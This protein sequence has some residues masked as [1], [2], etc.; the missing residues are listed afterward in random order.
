[1]PGSVRS[2]PRTLRCVAASKHP[3]AL[4]AALAAAAMLSAGA[5][6]AAAVPA[7][8]AL[9]A[10][11][12]VAGGTGTSGDTGQPADTAVRP[13]PPVLDRTLPVLTPDVG[14]VR[15][16]PAGDSSGGAEGDYLKQYTLRGVGEH[17]EV[18][19]AT[20]PAP[21]GV[22]GTAFPAGDCRNELPGAG[23]VTDEQVA[24]IVRAFDGTI[25]PT[26][27]AA[28]SVAPRRDGTRPA[29]DAL[30]DGP[31][32][33]FTGAADRTVLLVDNI[34]DD[35]FH[36]LARN[37][38]FLGGFFS[39][40]H[41]NLTDR[42][43]LTVDAFDW[44]HRNGA[45]PPS[46]P[47]AEPCRNQLARPYAVEATIAHEYQHL[48]QSYIDPGEET[49][50]DEG[51]SDYA[52]GLAGYSHAAL[53]QGEPGADDAIR[54]YLGF[55]TVVSAANPTPS[56]CG[57]P[58]NSL[59]WWE[60]E[61]AQEILADYGVAH[62]LMVFLAARYGPGLLRTLHNDADRQG[63]ASLQAALDEHA[64]GVSFADV[65]RD[66]HAATLLDRAVTGGQVTGVDGGSVTSPGF[67]LQVNL[68]NPRSYGTPGAAPNGADYV[69][70]AGAD[71][72]R[73]TGS[74]L[75]SLAFAG[76]RVLPARP[77]V[78]ATA[79]DSPLGGPALF[80]GNGPDADSSAVLPV[81]VPAAGADGAP[82][83]LTYT[84]SFALERGYDL[85]FTVVSTDGGRT[86]TPLRGT[87]TANGPL[88]PAFTGSS[89]G[90]RRVAFDLSAYAGR[91]VLLG[92]RHL[93]DGSTNAGG[94]YVADL[95][96]GG[97]PLGE[98]PV[99]SGLRT[100]T[101]I[102]D[103]PVAGWTVQVVGLDA[104]DRR[105]HVVRLAG[106][107]AQLTSDQV[108]SLGGFPA[109]VAIVGHEDPTG[110]IRQY[111]PYALTVNGVVQA[112]GR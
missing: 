33:D 58:Q 101:E 91:E 21:D 3:Y 112:G 86:Y 105:A 64:G 110:A 92:F 36:D 2:V 25:L 35:N 52:A 100:I 28:F 6:A 7:P 104:A 66:F 61:G 111:A 71:G 18:W 85:G 103:L 88:G 24:G 81:A 14:T 44:A 56:D 65:L 72:R 78:W 46:D 22:V 109:L 83:L 74:D 96:V 84:T 87:G 60:D 82:V 63:L 57:G 67:D 93:S 42:N 48:L 32:L 4:T 39:Q 45:N 97:R 15:L 98:R 41:S 19:V 73:L 62:A 55:G 31:E 99:P 1:M 50:L 20:G 10:P 12:A 75:R 79:A 76:A 69:P 80:S 16:W 11:A 106:P 90:P 54:C 26:S 51:L 49:F 53:P 94:W 47:S 102:V 89:D 108:A 37:R 77:M 17:L 27:S 68:A 59:T 8:A 5:S 43:V 107:E 23:T 30:T 38:T 29:A 13:P 40:R 9:P 34:R 70:L 95:E